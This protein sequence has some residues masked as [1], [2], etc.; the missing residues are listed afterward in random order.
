MVV[1]AGPTDVV[2]IRGLDFFGVNPPANG[3]RFVA[4][5]AL[6]LDQ[7]VIR[8]FNAS[9]SFGIMFIPSGDSKLY[10]SASTIADNGSGSTGGGIGVEPGPAGSAAVFIMDTIVSNNAGIG[11][12]AVGG[13]SQVHVSGT[14]ILGNGTGVAA[15]K[16]A[17]ISRLQPDLGTGLSKGDRTRFFR[18][19][20]RSR[21]LGR[22]RGRQRNA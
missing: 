13:K 18:K 14:S 4:G 16:G 22:C 17:T 12:A 6:H 7:V 2:Y 10:I 21:H 20:D 5:A 3:V 19:V 11:I 9:G 8:R 15:A 1:D